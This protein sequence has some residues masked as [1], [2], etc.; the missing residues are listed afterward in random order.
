MNWFFKWLRSKLNN[1][2]VEK[3]RV[4]A[5]EAISSPY[6]SVKHVDSHGMNFTVYKANGGYIVQYNQYDKRTDRSETK[7]HIVTEDKDLGEE[8][9]KIIS[10]EI[11]RG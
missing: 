4:Y 9:S 7:L 6:N 5:T 3:S 11:L 1:V 10:F 8:L 2:D